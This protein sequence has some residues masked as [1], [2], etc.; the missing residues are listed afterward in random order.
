MPIKASLTALGIVILAIVVFL[1]AQVFSTVTG[2]HDGWDI[3]APVSVTTEPVTVVPPNLIDGED[4][5]TIEAV[6][7]ESRTYGIPWSVYV[8]SD[9]QFNAGLDPETVA[10]RL[11]SEDPVESTEGADDGL[12]M[13]VIVPEADHTETMVEF[14]AGPNFYPKGGITP[15][16][17]EYIADVQ[18]GTLIE[19][20]R[21]GDA[22]IEGAT[23]VEWTQLFE[24]T[25]DPPPSNLERG[26]QD[27][28]E[29]LGAIGFA[30]L[31]L[32]VIGATAYAI[33]TTR[34]GSRVATP[35][36]LDAITAAAVARGRVDRAVIGGIILD[37]IDRGSFVVSD[38]TLVSPSAHPE[39]S[40]WDAELNNALSTLEERGQQPTLATVTRALSSDSPLK[41]HIEDR[42]AAGGMF[43]PRAPVHTSALRIIAI[44]GVVLGAVGIV[45]S[46]LG[47]LDQTLVASGSL[48]LISIIVL[49]WNE[50]RTWTTRVGKHALASWRDRHQA[51]DDRERVLYETIMTFEEL[52]TTPATRS[53]INPET[54]DLVIPALRS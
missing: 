41:F 15:E 21:I 5:E 19:E 40:G 2:E 48:T 13:V 32:L 37:A 12:L 23:W 25:P 49:I 43:A 34:L 30:G 33:V 51:D 20:D 53:P 7:S 52:E 54:R 18:M 22:V 50:R 17:L 6:V 26:L 28:L 10:E 16:R 35:M 46:A 31:A 9:D 4:Q 39:A 38:E 27:L 3:F 14:V 11:F 44:V 8:T 36:N 47:E 24:P 42:L 45:L 1:A 29:P